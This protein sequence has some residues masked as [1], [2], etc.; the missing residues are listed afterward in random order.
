MTDAPTILCFGDSNTHG[1]CPMAHL[2]DGRRFDR[3]QRW[4]AV[5]ARALGTSAH[6]IEEGHPG[7][8]TVHS[9]PIEGAHKNGFAVLPAILE[10]HRPLSLVVIM[11]GT[12]DLKERFSVPAMDIALSLGKLAAFARNSETGPERGAPEVLLIAP[13]PVVER[14]CLTEMFRGGAAKSEALRNLLKT[15]ANRQGAHFMDAAQYAAMSEVDGI[16]FDATAHAALGAGVADC[17]RRI[18]A[19]DRRP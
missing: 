14:G 8:T 13:P 6:A 10:S 2:D 19:L 17:A 11:L 16:H 12:N 18:L 9:D 4:P 3:S 15:E 5:M 1:T 7:R